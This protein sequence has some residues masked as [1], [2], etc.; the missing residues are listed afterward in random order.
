MSDK[1]LE[2]LLLVMNCEC[3]LLSELTPT[4]TQRESLNE[5]LLKAQSCLLDLWNENDNTVIKGTTTTEMRSTWIQH[6]LELVDYLE[7]CLDDSDIGLQEEPEI[8]KQKIHEIRSCPGYALDAALLGVDD[9]ISN[10]ISSRRTF[11]NLARG[12]RSLHPFINS[13]PIRKRENRL[14]TPTVLLGATQALQ[15]HQQSV[16]DKVVDNQFYEKVLKL[17]NAMSTAVTQV[18]SRAGRVKARI[19]RLR[20][21]KQE[22][23]LTVSIFQ[24]ALATL[25]GFR[26]A[27]YEVSLS[28]WI[29]SLK[30]LYSLQQD[31]SSIRFQSK[32]INELLS[33]ITSTI[34]SEYQTGLFYWNEITL[35]YVAP[36]GPL[37]ESQQLILSTRRNSLPKCFQTLV[38]KF[39]M[40]ISPLTSPYASPQVHFDRNV[41][42]AL[43]SS[44]TMALYT[45]DSMVRDSVV[46][47]ECEKRGRLRLTL[48]LYYKKESMNII[49]ENESTSRDELLHM[50]HES[51][52][53][54]A[55]A[56]ST[57]LR[58]E[59]ESNL[60]LLEGLFS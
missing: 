15:R 32:Q 16:S 43:L 9:C 60:R 11:S 18:I 25:E 49:N 33:T 53:Q 20:K 10:I 13:I 3:D 30:L 59:V 52:Q 28:E 17:V 29:C 38:A 42:P 6:T 8:V 14:P 41:T 4:D 45:I 36:F 50:Y 47:D 57:R 44:T 31:W 19:Q 22:H 34:T 5:E 51:A 46:S 54:T 2:N 35:K 37:N 7:E 48:V 1:W 24:T 12:R 21:E 56:E 39:E 26:H 58:S 27:W 40:D 23:G 55:I